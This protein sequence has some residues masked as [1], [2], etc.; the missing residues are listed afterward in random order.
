M[1]GS[2]SPYSGNP[3]EYISAYRH[4]YNLFP[5]AQN[6][7]KFAYDPNVAFPGVTTSTF[8]AYYPGSQFVDVVGLDGFDF[9]GQTFSQVFQPSL[10]AMHADF[11]MKPLWI[12]STG[13][14]DNPSE[15]IA[16]LKS[17]A[18]EY[19][20]QGIIWYDYQQFQIPNSTLQSL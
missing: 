8:Q 6:M 15:F 19:G 7:V 11:P 13:S 16:N 20:I 17:A 3:A 2:W 1:N 5:H 10:T 4:V 9:G 18:P 12:L 14:V